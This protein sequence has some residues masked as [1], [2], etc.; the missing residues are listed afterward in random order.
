MKQTNT[1]TLDPPKDL[2]ELHLAH[3][4]EALRRAKENAVPFQSRTVQPD[5]D[6]P[7]NSTHTP[8]DPA[9]AAP[10]P[11]AMP[12]IYYDVHRKEFLI[13]NST[14][15]WAARTEAQFK[16][17][18]RKLG[19]STDI[20]KG[21]HV[22][23]VEEIMEQIQD[24]RDVV[25][26]GPL[27]GW[28]AGFYID[29]GVRFL[30]TEEA[31]T[32]AGTRN[33]EN[34]DNGSPGISALSAPSSTLDAVLRGL[35][36]GPNEPHGQRQLDT[37]YSWLK[38]ALEALEENTIRPGQALAI[39]GPRD[40]GKSLLQNLIT[41]LLGG[42]AAKA[43]RYMMGRTEFNADLFEAEHLMLE[44]EFMS[45][46]TADRLALGAAIKNVTVNE[47]QSCHPKHKKAINLRPFWRLSISLN[48]D[49]EALMVLPPLDDHIADK[50]IILRASR[51]DLPMDTGTLETR[52]QFWQT[53]QD[54]LPAFRHFLRHLR[55]PSELADRRFGVKT[56]Q[57]PELVRD[58]EMLSPE[59]HL[60]ELI[61]AAKPWEGC[62][63][64][65][66]R[67]TQ[68][69]LKRLL[70]DHSEVGREAGKL[71][72]GWHNQCGAYLGR[73]AGKKAGRIRCARTKR[74]REWLIHPAPLN[75]TEVTE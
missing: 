44:D 28:R 29:H 18:L 11:E 37:L 73:L 16:R 35:L 71:L 55:V 32:G 41:H 68:D 43:A 40:C 54:E 3:G 20:P 27:A 10:S 7:P 63:K 48:H 8:P 30:V 26:A 25:Y 61:D 60:L 1:N 39:A 59:I 38:T 23:P 64:G 36:A 66:W 49:P 65:Y 52:A 58:L 9:P 57:H 70:L 22:S 74:K 51:F 17:Y 53:L 33:A 4:P 75:E 12:E 56:F 15:R 42:R 13:Q 2:N 34:A 62:E 24:E 31:N 6:T 21:K 50:I 67:G 14:G 69:E 5:P 46:R 19:F 47:L 45:T 72:S